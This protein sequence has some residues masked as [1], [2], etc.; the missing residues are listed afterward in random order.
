VLLEI[1]GKCKNICVMH[2]ASD[3]KQ[4]LSCIYGVQLGMTRYKYGL[5]KKLRTRDV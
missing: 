2:I 3:V 1:V 5:R 4:L